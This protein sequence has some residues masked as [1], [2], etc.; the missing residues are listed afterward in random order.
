MLSP[1]SSGSML[2]SPEAIIT[3]ADQLV[4]TPA[5]MAPEQI[6]REPV[7]ERTDVYAFGVTLYEALFGMRPFESAGAGVG[8]D[9]RTETATVGDVGLRTPRAPPRGTPVPRHLQR[10]L[11]KALEQRP[12]DRWQSMSDMLAALGRDPYRTWRR[13]GVAAL[14]VAAAAAVTVGFARNPTK[15]GPVCRAG[16]TRQQVVWGK[17][18]QDGVRAAFSGTGLP[19]AESAATTVARELDG[20]TAKL[21]QSADDACAATRVR[22]EQSEQAMDLRLAC[23]ESRWREVDALVGLLRHA[24]GETVEQSLKAVRSLA[25]LDEC[26]DVVALRAPTPKPRD[27]ETAAKVDA[28]EQRLASV[29]ATFAVGKSA[30]AAT[31][32][33]DLVDDARKVG[34]GPL[35]ARTDFW[36]GRA[37]A[38]LSQSD[39]SIPA[40]RAAFAESLS[41]HEDRVL[42][43]AA[44]RLAQEYIYA[45]QHGEFEFWAGVAQA[46]LDRGPAD[47]RLQS[48]LDH[49]RCV[50]LWAVGK[51]VTRL[52]CLEKHAAKVEPVRPLD[53]WELTTLGLAAVDVGQFERGLE[54]ARRGYEYSMRQNGPMHPRTLEMRM[55]VCKAQLDLEDYDAAL[56]ECGETLKVMEEV[57]SDNHALLGRNRIYMVDALAGEK[58]WEEAKAELA[59]AVAIGAAAEDVE[60]A[61]ARIDTETGHAARALPHWRE[62]L[63]AER[64][65]PAEHP[66]IVGAKLAL[67]RALL[68]SGNLAEAR[69]VLGE[70]L[71]AAERAELSPIQHADVEFAAA[72]ALWTADAAS[73]P[74]ALDLARHALETYVTSAPRTRGF[75]DARAEIDAWLAQATRGEGTPKPK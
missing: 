17:E 26:A 57:A 36:R 3:R 28:L 7:D 16:A 59:R 69:T 46:A 37:Y 11:F 29:M 25:P 1:T 18:A 60:E 21:A 75:T 53:E 54:Y 6:L 34:F 44:A 9:A 66:D 68:D 55:Y 50:A 42:A 30:G 43:E 35:V 10:I 8:S 73:K 32:G 52:S 33:E 49:T 71:A 40:F 48:F 51:I 20:Y 14:G 62:A 67:G 15:Q 74:R 39:K 12:A 65:L 22:A 61:T 23:Y 72:R 13:A 2:A 45:R 56:A 27:P 38:D 19:Y 24:D 63:A 41:S 5:Y 4:G 70:A 58:R 64:E 31:M 47:A